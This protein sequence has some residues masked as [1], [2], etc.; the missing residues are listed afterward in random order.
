MGNKPIVLSVFILSKFLLLMMPKSLPYKPCQVFALDDY[1]LLAHFKA[2]SDLAWP[3]QVFYWTWDMFGS[4]EAPAVRGMKKDL[5]S[6]A[7]LF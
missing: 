3:R 2:R 1:L 5:N 6:S 7:V 4:V